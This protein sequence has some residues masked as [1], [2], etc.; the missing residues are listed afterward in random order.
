MQTSS[1]EYVARWL[2]EI[3]N[4]LRIGWAHWLPELGEVAIVG[5]SA[6]LAEDLVEQTQ[7]RFKIPEDPQLCSVKG[8]LL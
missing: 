2:A 8:M 7:G 5:G 3:R 4:K 1:I 6:P